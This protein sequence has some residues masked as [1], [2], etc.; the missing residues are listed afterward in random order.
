MY[1]LLCPGES[2][3]FYR[4]FASFVARAGELAEYDWSKFVFD[5]LMFGIR[6][7]QALAVREVFG[8]VTLRVV[9][10]TTYVIVINYIAA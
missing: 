1:N 7:A 9:S 8:S 5:K 4:E 3:S 10:R 2:D 6:T